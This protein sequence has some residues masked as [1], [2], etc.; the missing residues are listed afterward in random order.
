MKNPFVIE[1]YVSS[2]FFCDREEETARI[3]E[4]LENRRNI[5]LISPRRLGK[6]GLIYRVFDQIKE[7]K[8]AYET[9]Y[10]DMSFTQTLEDFVKILSESVASVLHR[11]NK[12]KDIL[13]AVG[14]IRPLISYD[15]LTGQP[16]LSFT[17]RTEEDKKVTLRSL[18]SYMENSGKEVVVAIDEFQQIREYPGIQME[19]LLRTCI[20]PLHHV[21]FIFCGSNKHIMTD[22]FTN[23]KK[24]FY[25]STTNVPVGKLNE[26]TYERFISGLFEEYGKHIDSEL[27][28]DII[29]WTKDHTYYTQS[30][31][32]EVFSC[33]G[34]EVRSENVTQAKRTI[35]QMNTDRFL[36]IKRMT[37][38]SQWKL[39]KAVAKE[40]EVRKPTSAAFL[41]KHGLTS[42]PAVL[43]SLKSLVDKELILETLTLE[44]SIYSVYNVFLSRYLENL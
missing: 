19:A 6:T 23:A 22:M 42:G 7:N 44:G 25:E 15:E 31:C 41:S 38:P 8:L 17:Y 12:I 20:Q 4:C 34:K 35:L 26:Q 11:R 27:V 3:I 21:R 16:Q 14:G 13:K 30:L 40:G 39:L 29:R 37:T 36:E 32:N 18:F 43:K 9:I 5:T 1:P 2:H 28:K 24:P 33:S 10:A